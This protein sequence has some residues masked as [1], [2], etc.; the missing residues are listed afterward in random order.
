MAD[1][2]KVVSLF[3][4]TLHLAT[5]DQGEGRAFLLLHGGAGPASMAGL[6]EAL[7]RV[8]RVVVPVHPGFN[9]EPRPDWFSRVDDLVLAYLG[10][11]ERL[12][13]TDVILVG[14]S[15]GGWIASE[16]A[17]RQSGRIS[18]VVLLNGVGI[19]TGSPEKKIV[20]PMALEPAQ[21]VVLSFHNPQKFAFAPSGPQL[22]IMAENQ[23]T[24]RVYAGEPFMHDPTLL[25]RLAQVSVPALV[26]WGASDRI[27][28]ADY[29]RR[30]A[31]GFPGAR[32]ELVPEAGHFPQIE[33][34]D[35]VLG[36]LQQW[37]GSFQR[38]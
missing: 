8:G 31:H 22:A 21:R 17:L 29:G 3:S 5:T 37:T 30:F 23:K 13:L 19:D 1:Q 38:V 33:K 15:F 10:L 14:N 11:I 2:K 35:A 6:A 32:F 24:L 18:G 28:D 36:L 25:P 12:D 26:V 4:E 27:V 9:G 34:L 20:D 16:M 7:S